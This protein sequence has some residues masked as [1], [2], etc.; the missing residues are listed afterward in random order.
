MVTPCYHV[1]HEKKEKRCETLCEG[2]LRR[3]KREAEGMLF[4]KR[5][6]PK[7]SKG[8]DLTRTWSQCDKEC[9]W[10][11]LYNTMVLWRWLSTKLER[12][13]DVSRS[14]KMSKWAIGNETEQEIANVISSLREIYM[15]MAVFDEVMA[16]LWDSAVALY[17]SILHC[18]LSFGERCGWN[19]G[20]R[21]VSDGS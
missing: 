9:L 11:N 13:K 7:L 15:S 3:G 18:V 21:K 20:Y 2:E 19:C 12:K 5:D 10:L 8:V 14:F 1:S 6:V 16:I 17:S 4:H